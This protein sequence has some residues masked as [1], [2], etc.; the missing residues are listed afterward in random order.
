MHITNANHIV[1]G[2]E[3]DIED[4]GLTDD[5]VGNYYFVDFLHLIL[6]YTRVSVPSRWDGGTTWNREHVW[7]QSTGW[8]KDTAGGADIHHIRPTNNSANSSRGN[9]PFGEVSHTENNRKKV[10]ISGYGQ[11]D[12]GY[13]NSNFFEPLDEV[14][15]DIARIIFYLLVRYND[16]DS[17]PVTRVSQ[18]M[19]MLLRWHE[20]DPVDDF[21]LNRNEQSFKIQGNRNPFI[22]Y[23]DFASSVFGVSTI[24]LENNVYYYFK[25]EEFYI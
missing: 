10:T 1:C 5:I 21:E 7:P 11:V 20:Q 18:S 8:S 16:A 22:D 17:K 4:T 25:K 13:A 9:K 24:N 6:L 23:E 2:T 3:G 14:K 12:Y 19:E 15:G